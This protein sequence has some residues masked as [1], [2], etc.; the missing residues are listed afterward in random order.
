MAWRQPGDKPLSEAMM[1]RLPT[2]ICITRP[3]WVSTFRLNKMTAAW[4]IFFHI[5][6]FNEK[7]WTLIN[8]LLR[9][10]SYCLIDDMPT[11]FQI[12]ARQWSHESH[13]MNQ[14]YCSLLKHRCVT[15]LEWAKENACNLTE[16]SLVSQGVFNTSSF[17]VFVK[18]WSKTPENYCIV[19]WGE[20]KSIMNFCISR[21]QWVKRWVIIP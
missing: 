2:P 13:Y 14:C 9:F 16:Y 4:Q 18:D 6:L 8:I 11:L 10:N 17:K 5:P 7:V 20:W 15:R 3:Q 21:C 12:M 1:V 19:I